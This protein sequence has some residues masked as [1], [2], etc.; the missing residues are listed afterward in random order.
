VDTGAKAIIAYRNVIINGKPIY[1]SPVVP[2]IDV[3]GTEQESS[4]FGMPSI[5]FYEFAHS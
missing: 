3:T 1:A 4:R 2:I 5:T